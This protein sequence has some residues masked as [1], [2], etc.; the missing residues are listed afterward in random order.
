MPIDNKHVR[1]DRTILLDQHIS[2]LIR[3]DKHFHLFV[4]GVRRVR[5][6]PFFAFD[7]HLTERK[8]FKKQKNPRGL[9]YLFETP[10]A[11]AQKRHRVIVCEGGSDCCQQHF[12]IRD[13]W[14]GFDWVSGAQW[15]IYVH[16]TKVRI[17]L[18]LLQNGDRAKL[19]NLVNL[20]MLRNFIFIC[21]EGE[22][23]NN[24]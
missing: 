6:H 4:A 16:S 10:R 14:F 20:M 1:I 17:D 12:I 8:V 22:K 18:H 23:T 7:H 9:G 15:L 11:G 5:Y 24:F 2:E 13:R 19:I 21:R 3:L